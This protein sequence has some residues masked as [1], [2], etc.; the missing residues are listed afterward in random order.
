MIVL[1]SQNMSRKRVAYKVID[2]MAE[3]TVRDENTAQTYTLSICCKLT[4]KQKEGS[5]WTGAHEKFQAGESDKGAQAHGN[6]VIHDFIMI[7]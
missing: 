5:S 7:K 6:E 1:W 3:G 4:E 2:G